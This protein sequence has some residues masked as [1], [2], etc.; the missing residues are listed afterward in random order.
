MFDMVSYSKSLQQEYQVDGLGS[1]ACKTQTPL[2]LKVN[3][4]KGKRF[5]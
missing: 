2:N 1:L 4:G 5:L 3:Y